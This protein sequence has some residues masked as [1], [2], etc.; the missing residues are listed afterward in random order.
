VHRHA[1]HLADLLSDGL[2][3]QFPKRF[4]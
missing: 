2:I 4:R 1:L 3:G